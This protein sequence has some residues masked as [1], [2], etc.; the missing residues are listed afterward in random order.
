MLNLILF[1]WLKALLLH[2]ATFVLLLVVI[3]FLPVSL[4]ILA[5]R[6]YWTIHKHNT[7]QSR[8]VLT[9]EEIT[10]NYSSGD[11]DALPGKET[12]TNVK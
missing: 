4:A 1:G 7:R 9:Y 5:I 2:P 12:K 3:V 10:R 6:R 8:R 11:T